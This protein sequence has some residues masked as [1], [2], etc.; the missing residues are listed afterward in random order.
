[1]RIALY[2]GLFALCSAPVA[3][4]SGH[5]DATPFT[6]GKPAAPAPK[7]E[8]AAPKPKKVGAQVAETKP[9]PKPQAE[10]RL[11]APCKDK[12]AKKGG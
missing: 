5:C 8:K 2:L 9:L 12:K 11:F 6:L 1:M 3:A 7:V 10:Q 4:E